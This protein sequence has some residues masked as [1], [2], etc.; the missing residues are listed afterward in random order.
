MF[1]SV[2]IA[3]HPHT[4]GSLTNPNM[5]AL[6]FDINFLQKFVEAFP[7]VIKRCCG[8]LVFYKILIGHKRKSAVHPWLGYIFGDHRN[9]PDGY[10]ITNTDMTINA[11][12]ACKN[13]I[14]TKSRA[15]GSDE[16]GKD[17]T[18]FA[19]GRVVGDVAII[20]DFRSFTNNCVIEG[21]AVNVHTAAD[22]NPVFEND[23][24]EVGLGK[25]LPIFI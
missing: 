23:F 20:V 15:A 7:H 5:A 13:A 1:A 14:I 9:R 24:A 22:F 4:D 8:G 18:I 12:P 19:D 10:A 25:V 6:F 3:I 16:S 21:A 2:S 17:Q 11:C